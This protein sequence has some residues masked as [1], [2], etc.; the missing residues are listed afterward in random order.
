MVEKYKSI[1]KVRISELVSL[2]N[3]I[4]MDINALVNAFKDYGVDKD[5]T[6]FYG[7]TVLETKNYT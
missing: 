7:P 6:N 1:Y 4:S 3:E 2:K 5:F